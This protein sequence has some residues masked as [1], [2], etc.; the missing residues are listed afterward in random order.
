MTSEVREILD[1]FSEVIHE[2]H[3]DASRAYT[4]FDEDEK[5]LFIDATI[6][7]Q[8]LVERLEIFIKKIREN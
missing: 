5:E 4:Y 6:P 1:I 2:A 7:K 3:Q 8:K